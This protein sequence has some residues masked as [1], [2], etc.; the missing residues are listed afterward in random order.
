MVSELV[1]FNLVWEP[2]IHSVPISLSQAI[3]PRLQFHPV[4]G[5][6]PYLLTIHFNITLL[7]VPSLPNIFFFLVGFEKKNLY[8]FLVSPMHVTCRLT[9]PS[10]I[11]TS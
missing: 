9:P 11:Q 1:I 4:H 3:E 2:N 6:T 5:P 10:F 7:Y 8:T